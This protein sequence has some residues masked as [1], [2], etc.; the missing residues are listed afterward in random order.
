MDLMLELSLNTALDLGDPE[1]R[2][3]LLDSTDRRV[4]TVPVGAKRS[5]SA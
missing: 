5:S 1:I 2:P 3:D 4:L